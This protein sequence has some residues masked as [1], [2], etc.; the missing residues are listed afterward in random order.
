MHLLVIDVAGIA[1]RGCPH[2][3]GHIV[4]IQLFLPCFIWNEKYTL[5]T[6]NVAF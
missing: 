6:V 4:Y 5:R 3:C 2:T 1:K